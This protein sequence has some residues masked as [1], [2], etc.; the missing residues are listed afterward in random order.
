MFNPYA[1]LLV[2][3]LFFWIAIMLIMNH[4]EER[5]KIVP[6]Y[7]ELWD[8]SDKDKEDDK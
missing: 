6:G 8:L 4:E 1:F 3:G 7:L 2:A 5:D